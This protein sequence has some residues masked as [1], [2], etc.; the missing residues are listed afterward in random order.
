MGGERVAE[1]LRGDVGVGGAARMAKQTGVVGLR[2]R[3]R[4]EP[5]PASEPRRDQRAVQPVLE[6]EPHAEVGGQ[7]Q[8]RDHLRAA[9]LLDALRRLVC[10]APTLSEP[11]GTAGS[12]ALVPGAVAD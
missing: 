3:R 9:D 5:E 1:H 4:I 2:C 7:A 12:G 10:H 11:P 6:R 8:R